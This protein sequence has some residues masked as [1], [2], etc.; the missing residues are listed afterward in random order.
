MSA[1]E[2]LRIR[3]IRILSDGQR[4]SEAAIRWAKEQAARDRGYGELLQ[5]GFTPRE[6]ALGSYEVA[7]L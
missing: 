2:I 1:P 7:A 3:A 4:H 6:L 5:A